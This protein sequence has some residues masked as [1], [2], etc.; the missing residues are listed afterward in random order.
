MVCVIFMINLPKICS[1]LVNGS[2]VGAE[3]GKTFEV[4]NPMNGKVMHENS[5]DFYH[6]LYLLGTVFSARYGQ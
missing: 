5:S 3:S 1:I 6:F 2:W 4:V